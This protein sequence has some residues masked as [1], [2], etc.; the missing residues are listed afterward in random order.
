LGHRPAQGHGD[1]MLARPFKRVSA[2]LI[3]RAKPRTTSPTTS[4]CGRVSSRMPNSAT[5]GICALSRPTAASPKRPT[6]NT[7]GITATA[8]IRNPFL[9]EPGL[10]TA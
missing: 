8:E 1:A 9:S 3:T 10:R 6:T 2:L 4:H 5:E 7:M